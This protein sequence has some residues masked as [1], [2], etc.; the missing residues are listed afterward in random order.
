MLCP[1]H[2]VRTFTDRNRLLIDRRPFNLGLSFFCAFLSLS[3]SLLFRFI[4]RSLFCCPFLFRFSLWRGTRLHR[5]CCFREHFEFSTRAHHFFCLDCGKRS[6]SSSRKHSPPRLDPS[7]SLS[8][9]A[10]NKFLFDFNFDYMYTIK[11]DIWTR[12][13]LLFPQLLLKIATIFC[14]FFSSECHS[15][16]CNVSTHLMFKSFSI[17]S[18]VG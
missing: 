15:Q 16:I 18:C 6:S 1:A 4:F 17:H 13:R 14:F 8:F 9:V 10:L 12:F 5:T 7:Y 11:S 3:L 2:W